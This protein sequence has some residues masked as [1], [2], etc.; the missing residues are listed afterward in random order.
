M[1][2]HVLHITSRTDWATG[3]AEGEYTAA[4]LGSE[5]FIHCSRPGQVVGVANAL[6]RGRDDLVLLVIAVERLTARL[7]EE[8]P[9]PRLD[10]SAPGETFPHL[11]GP[12]NLDAVVRVVA[13]PPHPD[14]TFTL[15]DDVGA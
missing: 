15:P 7:V 8:A 6:Y 12:L 1:D 11:Y 5:G 14:G 2:S 3:Q 9:Q 10:D 13:F 4:S